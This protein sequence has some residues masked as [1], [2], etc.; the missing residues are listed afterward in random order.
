MG[1]YVMVTNRLFFWLNWRVWNGKGKWKYIK[2]IFKNVKELEIAKQRIHVTFF[3]YHWCFIQLTN[4]F[5]LIFWGK[6][7]RIMIILCLPAASL[8]KFPPFFI[9]MKWPFYH[10]VLWIIQ[11]I[12]YL[13]CI[14]P[15]FLEYEQR[16]G[17]KLS[18]YFTWGQFLDSWYS[19]NI[20]ENRKWCQL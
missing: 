7:Q 3:H 6:F 13:D 8:V 9:D 2:G 4:F 17:L 20:A 10:P 16:N 19:F 18:F 15:S 14:N 5:T 12:F 11:N 1:C